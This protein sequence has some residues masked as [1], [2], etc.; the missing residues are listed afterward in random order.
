MAMPAI[1]DNG[2]S[3][4][5]SNVALASSGKKGILKKLDHDYVEIILGAFSAFGNGGWLYDL[6]TARRYI[7]TDREFLGL[8]QSGRLRSEWGHPVRQPWMSDQDWFIRICTILESNWSSHI[9]K[10]SLSYDTVTDERGRKVVA[11]IGEVCPTGPKAEEFR[12]QLENPYEDVNYSIRSFAKKNFNNMTK[13]VTKIVNWD[14]VWIPGIGVTSKYN[15]PSL[16]SKSDVCR[17]LD[18]AEFNIMRLREGFKN[19]TVSNDDSFESM[20]PYVKILDGLYQESK[21]SVFMPK[22]LSW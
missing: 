11:V 20:S 9:R 4:S 8:I 12:R 1:K 2:T 13:H 6:A 10:I 5:Y 17:M 18:E 16:E 21:T 14:N 22:T 19:D 3:V 7:E 15:T